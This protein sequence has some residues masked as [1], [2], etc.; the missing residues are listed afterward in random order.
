MRTESRG[1][2]WWLLQKEALELASAL[3]T[4]SVG[5][6]D[7]M[8]VI[9]DKLKPYCMRKAHTKMQHS[10]GKN[11]PV[12]KNQTLTLRAPF[13]LRLLHMVKSDNIQANE[14]ASLSTAADLC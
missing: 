1:L 5:T 6:E 11:A 2:S 10:P 4:V 12:C 14:P 9:G 3:F 8:S 7:A 13:V